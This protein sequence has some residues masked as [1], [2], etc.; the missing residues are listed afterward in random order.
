MKDPD[1]R[2]C[3]CS[4]DMYQFAQVGRKVQRN[5]TEGESRCEPFISQLCSFLMKALS[6]CDFGSRGGIGSFAG[7]G[8]VPGLGIADRGPRGELNA[9]CSRVWA[10]RAPGVAVGLLCES[11]DR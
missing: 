8:G 6:Q 9:F 7:D 2:A 10:G 4:I 1:L 11:C 3:S 5:A